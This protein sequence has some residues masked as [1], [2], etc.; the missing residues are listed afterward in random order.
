MSVRRL[1]YL[2]SNRLGYYLSSL[3]LICLFLASFNLR[4]P[5]TNHKIDP[6]FDTYDSQ[7]GPE[8]EHFFAFE[9]TLESPLLELFWMIFFAQLTLGSLLV[10]HTYFKSRIARRISL[11]LTNMPPPLVQVV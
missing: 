7:S 4:G 11:L 10:P 1:H 9:N 5:Q 8:P 6:Y 3:A 2:P